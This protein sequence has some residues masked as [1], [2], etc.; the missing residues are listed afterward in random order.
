MKFFLPILILTFS[1]LFTSCKKDSPTAPAPVEGTAVIKGK[2]KLLNESP[3]Y[4]AKIELRNLSTNSV[5]YDTC[6]YDGTFEFDKQ[7]SGSYSIYFKGTS[8]LNSAQSTITV[9]DDEEKSQDLY[10]KYKKLDDFAA[11]IINTDVIFMKFQPEGAMIGNNYESVDHFSGFYSRDINN[12]STLSCMIYKI[13]DTLNWQNPGVE[14]TADYIRANFEYLTEVDEKPS[15]FSGHEIDFNGDAVPV[16]LS[17]PKNGF[18]FVKK[19]NEGKT[20]KIPCTDFMNNDFG[21]M[22]FYK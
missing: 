3:A 15:Q 7:L 1:I 5:G 2:V 16:I 12:E 14:L 13:P 21:L 10:L 4:G 22:I 6:G 20:L 18:A 17:N 9:K 19:D 8:D 11:I